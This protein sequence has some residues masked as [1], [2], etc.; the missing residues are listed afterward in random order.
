MRPWVV[1]VLNRWSGTRIFTYLVPNYVIMIC[2]GAFAGTLWAARRA[3]RRGLDPDPLY[4]LILWAFPLALLGAR[5]LHWSYAPATYRSLL[6]LLDPIQGDSLAYGGF[7]AGTGAAV[8]YLLLRAPE[9]WRYLDCAAPALGLATAFTRV[10]CFLDGCDFGKVTGSPLSV[11]FP[12][13]S[14]AHQ[15]QAASG[16]ISPGAT[17]SLPVHPVQLYLALKGLGLAFLTARFGRNPR[18]AP[19]EEFCAFWVLYACARFG[20]EF[21]RGDPARGFWGPLSTSQAVSLPV[22]VLGAAGLWVRRRHRAVARTARSG[23]QPPAAAEE[24][25]PARAP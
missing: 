9:V 5:L 24:T 15:V 14:P 22:F 1:E 18:L 8:V 4:G 3:R 12:A 2:L 13:G 11:C 19:G 16:L 20:L 10:G 7:I 6:D 17:E 23:K 21:L 25:W